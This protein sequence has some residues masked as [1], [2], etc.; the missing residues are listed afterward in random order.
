MP[1]SPS[2]QIQPS[3]R[4]LNKNGAS[5]KEKMSVSPFFDIESVSNLWYKT[6]SGSSSGS[7]LPVV[8]YFS[9]FTNH[10]LPITNLYD[11]IRGCLQSWDG[12]Q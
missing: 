6:S 9:L 5:V 10:Q 7:Q 12:N 3:F 4:I 11:Q 2:C 1:E 8:K